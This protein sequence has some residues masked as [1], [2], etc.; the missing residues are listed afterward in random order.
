MSLPYR[1]RFHYE[2]PGTDIGYAATRRSTRTYRFIAIETAVSAYAP[3][4]RAR[5]MLCHRR[6]RHG[7]Q[8]CAITCEVLIWP[9]VVCYAMCH[10]QCGSGG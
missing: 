3:L 5:G 7:L 6:Y 10:V 1:L 9:M 2:M 4:M 8:C